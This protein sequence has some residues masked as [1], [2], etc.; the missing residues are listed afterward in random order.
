MGFKIK[1]KKLYCKY[2]VPGQRKS[3]T[4]QTNETVAYMKKKV[5]EVK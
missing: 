5:R 3:L 4:E 2:K 1:D